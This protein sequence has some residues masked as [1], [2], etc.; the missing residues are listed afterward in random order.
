M[1]LSADEK[2]HSTEIVYAAVYLY[3]KSDT[4]NFVTVDPSDF[5]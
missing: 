2:R 5:V 4:V 1:K 3:S